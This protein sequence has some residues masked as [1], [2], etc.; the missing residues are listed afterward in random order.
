MIAKCYSRVP[1]RERRR[2]YIILYYYI[3]IIL[4]V[5]RDLYYLVITVTRSVHGSCA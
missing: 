2:I 4:Y 3:I 5:F 1:H